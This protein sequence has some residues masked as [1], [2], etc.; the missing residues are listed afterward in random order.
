METKSKAANILLIIAIIGLLIFWSSYSALQDRLTETE[1]VLS[2]R[3]D[4]YVR[5][6]DALSEANTQIEDAQ[7]YAWSSYDEMG[8]TLDNLYTVDF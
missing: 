7:N 3:D 2:E 1:D 4:Q 6:S 8:E 5:C